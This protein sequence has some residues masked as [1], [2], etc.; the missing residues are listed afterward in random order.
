MTTASYW[1]RVWVIQEFILA[2]KVVLLNTP[3][4][5]DLGRA[6]TLNSMIR[7]P[8]SSTGSPKLYRG[9]KSSRH[10]Y[11][12]LTRSRADLTVAQC[13]QLTRQREC[14]INKDRVY[15]MLALCPDFS[16][17]KVRYDIPDEKLLW[18]IVMLSANDLLGAAD[19]L[20]VD[21]GVLIGIA[22]KI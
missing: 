21:Y 2:A 20:T 11:P 19:G 6:S 15:S 7:R 17:V 10:E 5:I 13:L 3:T 16:Q 8:R 4:L 22:Y 12:D 18:Q 1:K 14:S 9:L